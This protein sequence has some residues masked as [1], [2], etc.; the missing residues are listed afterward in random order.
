MDILNLFTLLAFVALNLD[1]I[2]Q[3][4]HVFKTKSSRDIS[5]PGLLIRLFAIV[6]ILIKYFALSDITLV[7]GQA[8][9]LLTFTLYL[10]L[11]V[12]YFI[13]RK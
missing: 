5:L 7:I 9:I 11:A 12:Y 2:F 10:G 4:I 6:I 13:R 3:T 1:I 8:L